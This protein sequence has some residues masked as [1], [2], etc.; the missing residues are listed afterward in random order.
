[1]ELVEIVA[2]G[3]LG[4][5]RCSSFGLHCYNRQTAWRMGNV[6]ILGN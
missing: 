2:N 3:E 1:M 6:T 5:L 4:H